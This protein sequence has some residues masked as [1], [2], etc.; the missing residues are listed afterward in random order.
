MNTLAA[1]LTDQGERLHQLA[2]H[3]A[4]EGHQRIAQSAVYHAAALALAAQTARGLEARLAV[5]EAQLAGARAALAQSRATVRH[6]TAELQ[7]ED[8]LRQS[9]PAHQARQR[10]IDTLK[11]NLPRTTQ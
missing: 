5:A 10:V 1:T 6:L 4:A 7:E 11:A 9:D 8:T 3:L 2:H